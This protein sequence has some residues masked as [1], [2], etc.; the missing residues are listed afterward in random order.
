[1][2]R[3][4]FVLICACL[5]AANGSQ[6]GTLPSLLPFGVTQLGDFDEPWA[7]VFLPDGALLIT[8]KAGKLI[9]YK[10]GNSERVGGVP[11]VADRG[12]GGLG[13]VILHPDF[14]AN[15][16]VYLS[17]SEPGE[18]GARGAAVA[19]A[20]LVRGEGKAT[21]EGLQVIWRQQPKVTGSGHF[22][23]RLA[24]GPDRH[25]WVTSGE[26]QKFTPAQDMQANLGKV[27]RLR[28]DGGIPEDNPFAAQGGV[29][30]QIWSLGHRNPLGIAFDPRGRLWVHEMG[31]RGGDELNL[32]E[33]GGNF[34]YPLVSNGDHYSGAVIPDHYTQPQFNAPKISWTPVIAPAGMIIYTG[35]EF[36]DWQGDAFIGGLASRAL[37]RVEFSGETAR[38]AARYDM[39]ERIREVEQGP[40]GAIW[41]LEDG[42]RRRAGRLLRLNRKE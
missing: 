23:Q 12:Q 10:D 8:E 34:G 28:E 42:D 13:D 3:S 32:I 25:L 36:P 6:G 18:G 9:L 35:S 7:M 2:S 26:R 21:L 33:R 4:I 20:K 5:F 16:F 22:G 14:A 1:M 17:Y 24:F 41:I 27:L 19:R 30:A 37:I 38:E 31:P 29:P 11:E 40:D 39:G 15:G